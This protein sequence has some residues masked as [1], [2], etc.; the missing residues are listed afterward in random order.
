MPT[1]DLEM[2]IPDPVLGAVRAVAERDDAE[3][4][5]DFYRSLLDAT[6]LLPAEPGDDAGAG[7][8]G[9]HLFTTPP[10]GDGSWKLLVFT[11]A[12]AAAAWRSEGVQLVPRAARD[13]F[14]F[15][16]GSP[17]SGILLNVAGP[18]GGELT[19]REFAALAEGVLPVA[20]PDDV[21]ELQLEP[22]AE[23]L[24]A[25]L[26]TPAGEAFLGVLTMAL[27]ESGP[28]RTAWLADV[29]FEAGELHPAVGVEL[30]DGTDESAQRGIFEHVMSRVQPLLGHGRYLDFIVVDGDVWAPMFSSAGPPIYERSPA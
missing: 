15:A 30:E 21:E 5:R 8:D 11:D 1:P 23:V 24:V 4:R 29:A 18:A 3:T 10:D 20:D 19:R 25:P 28:V 9:L 7:T 12:V 6:V 26:Q 17:T 16:V 2:P 22:G 14:A 13:V 27:R